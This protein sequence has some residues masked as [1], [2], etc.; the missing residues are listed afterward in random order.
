MN[1]IKILAKLIFSGLSDIFFQYHSF[2]SQYNSFDPVALLCL[3]LPELQKYF[4][5][6]SQTN[7]WDLRK[8]KLINM[9]TIHSIVF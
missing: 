9:R 4:F 1:L 8:L 3:I 5:S 6:F 2:F 7:P